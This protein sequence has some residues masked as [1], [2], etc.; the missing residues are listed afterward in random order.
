MPTD[1]ERREPPAVAEYLLR[2]GLTQS[3]PP[4]PVV[5]AANGLLVTVPLPRPGGEVA[6]RGVFVGPSGPERVGPP[7]ETHRFSEAHHLTGAS[8]EVADL[9]AE[10]ARRYLEETETLDERVAELQGRE[11]HEG[12]GGLAE[13]WR[14]GRAAARLRAHLGRALVAMA[15][16][17]RQ[18]AKTFPGLA[19]A[20]PSLRSELERVEGLLASVQQAVS[21]LILLRNAEQANRLA[22]T[23]NDLG[24]LSNRIA[25]LQ[26]ISNIRMLG[27][28][29]LALI[30]AIIG[31]VVLI[32]N[33]GATILGMPSAGWVPG[34]WVDGILAV[35]AVVPI[36][37]VFSRPW[38]RQLLH[39]MG[40]Y[41]FRVGEGMDELPERVPAASPTDAPP[42]GRT[43]RRPGASE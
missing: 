27:I 5:R 6:W 8:A 23:A 26:N 24:R 12:H 21:D 30:L 17:E 11:G 41:E 35:L 10:A 22:A 42:G 14:A 9:L 13:V 39:G 28:T 4:R 34:L 20:L 15:E 1:A 40:T 3:V 32:P 7:A 36:V 29:Y 37:L 16:L 38:V 33:T 31:A 2:L 43:E 19:D 25:E 18:P